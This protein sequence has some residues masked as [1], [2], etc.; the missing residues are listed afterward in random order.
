[1][2]LGIHSE[3][4][5][6]FAFNESL[7]ASY[8]GPLLHGARVRSAVNQH[9]IISC[10]EIVADGYGIQLGSFRFFKKIRLRFHCKLAFLDILLALKNRFRF[11]GSEGQ[12]NLDQDQYVI[13]HRQG[14]VVQGEFEENTDYFLLDF[15]YRHTIV[16]ELV[17]FFSPLQSFQ[18]A[19]ARKKTFLFSGPVWT[20]C[21]TRKVIDQIL[22]TPAYE[23][24]QELYYFDKKIKEF[25]FLILHYQFRE[26]ITRRS[27]IPDEEERV[28][29]VAQAISKN[30]RKI[31]SLPELAHQAGMNEN[32]LQVLFKRIFRKNVSEYRR[33]L[34]LEEARRLIVEERK[35]IKEVFLTVGYKSPTAFITEF[36]KYFG[37][38]P[39]ALK[40]KQ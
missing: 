4:G 31:V 5:L 6:P 37:Y 39:G 23:P 13:L 15:Q 7:P 35:Q 29:L 8:S 19:I 18:S 30:F 38:P 25:L 20:P 2:F 12:Y 22:T 28:R 10:Q 40:K 14:G 1:M 24:A 26:N 32:K 34:R 36:K 16:K 33:D 3:D 17:P 27:D 9:G 11:Q 21:S